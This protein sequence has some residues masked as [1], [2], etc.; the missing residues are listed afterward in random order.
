M[1][2]DSLPSLQFKPFHA[3]QPPELVRHGHPHT[4]I[5]SPLSL[6]PI[7]ASLHWIIVGVFS[8]VLILIPPKEAGSWV[9]NGQ[10]TLF[11][12]TLSSSQVETSQLRPS[13]Q[14]PIFRV[15]EGAER[16][17]SSKTQR[18]KSGHFLH[19]GK[20]RKRILSP[21]GILIPWPLPP[22]L[23]DFLIASLFNSWLPVLFLSSHWIVSS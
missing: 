16:K 21:S 7:L 3:P 12:N 15:G 11:P 6:S 13:T 19:V 18:G 4:C 17:T 20:N 9:S 10:L 14:T 2:P 1:F 23:S 5:S 8:R 22:I